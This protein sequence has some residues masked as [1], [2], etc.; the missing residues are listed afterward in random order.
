M[1]IFGGIDSGCFLGDFIG[2]AVDEHVTIRRKVNIRSILL[3][4]KKILLFVGIF[5]GVAVAAQGQ[6][7][8]LTYGGDYYLSKRNVE[9]G[10]PVTRRNI[11]MLGNSLTERGFWSEYFQGQR[12]LN[13]G[14]GGDCISGMIARAE[15]IV[16]GQPK[17]VF[18]MAGANDL[19]FSRIS[20][21][22]LLGQYERLLDLFKNRSPRTKIYIQSLLP[23]NELLNE[24]FFKGKNQRIVAFNS[25]LRQ[26][27][28]R[29]GLVYIDLWTSLQREGVLP[30]EY[31][32]D[33]IHLKAAGYQRWA[34]KI[35]PYLR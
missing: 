7:D 21:E 11:V 3:M 25:L 2:S 1:S 5:W 24:K 12:L 16:A 34:E 10:T 15:P 31:T 6:S 8:T 18:I 35:A 14:I 33:G 27:A 32:F 20:C 9:E 22:R 19:I 26:M 4:M 13:R 30:D 29:R 23:L 28:E 17:A